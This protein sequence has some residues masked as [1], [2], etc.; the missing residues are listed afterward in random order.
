MICLMC[1]KTFLQVLK[2]KDILVL[3]EKIQPVFAKCNLK[4]VQRERGGIFS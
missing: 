2:L 1:N 3:L 4:K